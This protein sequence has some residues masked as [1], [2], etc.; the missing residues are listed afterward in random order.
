MSETVTDNFGWHTNSQ[1]NA[2]LFKSNTQANTTLLQYR[3][4]LQSMSEMILGIREA[5]TNSQ[6]NILLQSHIKAHTSAAYSNL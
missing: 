6:L 1:C 5:P 3:I 2:M 4:N